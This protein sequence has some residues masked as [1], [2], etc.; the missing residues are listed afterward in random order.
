MKSSIS[1]SAAW[2]FTTRKRTQTRSSPP[3]D[4]K[5]PRTRSSAQALVEM[6]PPPRRES[7]LTRPTSSCRRNS[8]SGCCVRRQRYR[9][10]PIRNSRR[11][12]DGA[13]FN[14]SRQRRAR[15]S[16]GT[17]PRNRSAPSCRVRRSRSRWRIDCTRP[18]RS[19]LDESAWLAWM[20][21][22]VP[23]ENLHRSTPWKQG[24]SMGE[25][26]AHQMEFACVFEDRRRET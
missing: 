3:L 2:L 15:G 16:C 21:S 20:F 4:D 11:T 19:G 14:A 26:K 24:R 22:V 7:L 18:R 25:E 9:V 6:T 12:P 17:R 23:S 10:A 13:R 1:R 5:K 8:E